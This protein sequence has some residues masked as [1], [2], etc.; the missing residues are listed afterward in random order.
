M[1]QMLLDAYEVGSFSHHSLSSSTV[2]YLLTVNTLPS[3][4]VLPKPTG[5]L[6]PSSAPSER[7]YWQ[8]PSLCWGEVCQQQTEKEVSML[9][10]SCLFFSPLRV[11]VTGK[12]FRHHPS[13]SE[14]DVVDRSGNR[15]RSSGSLGSTKHG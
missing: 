7:S 1:L 4:I 8:D 3:S 6:S 5:P 12:P 15:A 10:T 13:S 11:S 14:K 9:V 2:L